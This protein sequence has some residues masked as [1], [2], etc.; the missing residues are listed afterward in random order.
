[1]LE[2]ALIPEAMRGAVMLATARG[3][4]QKTLQQY[5]N[6]HPGQLVW[7]QVK[8][9]IITTYV[10]A[11]H[12]RMMREELHKAEKRKPET[13]SAYLQRYQQLAELAYPQPDA[14]Q[15]ENIV[16]WLCRGMKDNNLVRRICRQGRPVTID[17]VIRHVRESMAGNEA[18]D[19]VL[20][21]KEAAMDISVLEA[22]VASLGYTLLKTSPQPPLQEQQ[23]ATEIAK[24]KARISQL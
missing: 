5:I 22:Q 9:H 7:E 18:A 1:M 21:R 8:V 24:L 14:M 13:L 20:G 19:N 15:Q 10:S 6:A 23:A 16:R 17:A 12:T 2:I 4:L 3:P 11:D